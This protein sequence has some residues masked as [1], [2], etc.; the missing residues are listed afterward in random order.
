MRG[1][2]GNPPKPVKVH[3]PSGDLQCSADFYRPPGAGPFPTIVMAH[4]LGGTKLQRL[5]AF[6]ERFAAAGYAC[7]VFDY[8]Y[9]G[10][11]AGVPRQMLSIERQLEDWYAAIA[12][13]RGLGDVDPAQIVLWG[14]SFAGG[15]VLSV[16]ADDGRIAAVISQCPFTDGLASSLAM[17]PWNSLKV[18][19]LALRD[20]VGAW[21]GGK[22][23]QVPLA[24]RPG[25]T[26]LM[27]APDAYAGYLALQPP[28]A[29]IP[30]YVAA[31]IALDI[32]RYSPGR[33]A[34]EIK[35]P[36]LFC[37]CDPDSVAPS[38][39]T[40]RH[41]VRAPHPEIKRYAY[42]HFEI[43]VG[44]AFEVVVADQ[45]DFLHRTVPTSQAHPRTGA[46]E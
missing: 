41:A 25:Q 14:T 17:N 19:A 26:A 7:L 18:T 12:F 11:S 28:G 27:N 24:G 2:S 33:R 8:R 16:A 30:N 45:L 40:L 20:R 15:H 31:R 3:F 32:I 6:A 9:F 5:W 13:A 4:G 29:N 42:G 43:Y 46:H 35:R 22:P 21:F 10:D 23:V 36:I 44:K 38:K 34:R 39:A 37:V 1:K